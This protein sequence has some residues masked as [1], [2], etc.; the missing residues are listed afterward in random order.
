M[1]LRLRGLG[2]DLREKEF[3]YKAIGE[4]GKGLIDK[5]LKTQALASRNSIYSTSK[6]NSILVAWFIHVTIYMHSSTAYYQQTK[7]SHCTCTQHSLS[8]D[9]S[10]TA[11]KSKGTSQCSKELNHDA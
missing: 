11:V 1:H 5:E 7:H 8:M 6:I 9:Q 3:E 4:F 2:N 10:T